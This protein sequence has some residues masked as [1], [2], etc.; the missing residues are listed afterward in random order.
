LEGYRSHSRRTW[1]VRSYW[2]IA[3]HARAP[4]AGRRGLLGGV[5]QKSRRNPL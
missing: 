3:G 1:R 5:T 4:A 2:H